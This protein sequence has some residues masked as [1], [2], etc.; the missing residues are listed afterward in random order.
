LNDDQ[1]DQLFKVHDGLVLVVK[2][3]IG[4]SIVCVIAVFGPIWIGL[5]ATEMMNL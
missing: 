4:A 2:A 5:F 1:F 3:A